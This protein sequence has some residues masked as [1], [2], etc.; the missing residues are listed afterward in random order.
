MADELFTTYLGDE[1][2]PSDFEVTAGNGYAICWNNDA[3]KAISRSVNAWFLGGTTTYEYSGQV[4]IT[5]T[6]N[7]TT[8]LNS[9]ADVAIPT[10]TGGWKMGGT[11]VWASSTPTATEIP[12][13]P[14]PGPTGFYLGGGA[15]LGEPEVVSTIPPSDVIVPEGGFA[16]CGSAET[17]NVATTFPASEVIVAAAGF[18]LGGEGVWGQV[19][20]A[21]ILSAVLVPTGGFILSGAGFPQTPGVTPTTTVIVPTG[22]WKFGG[23]QPDSLVVVY[24]GSAYDQ[25]IESEVAFEMGGEGIWGAQEDS[26]PSSTVIVSDGAIF[27]LAGGGLTGT[28]LSP[29]AVITGDALGGFVLGGGS[30]FPSLAEVYEA[31]CLSGQ[32]FEPSVFSGFNFNSFA[33]K[34]GQAY[35]ANEDGIYLLGADTDAGDPIQSGIRLGP[36]NAGFD[37]EKRLRSC[38]F[39]AG[40]NGTSVRVRTDD[41]REGVFKPE[42]DS[43]RVVVSRDL[44][45][46]EF[47]LDVM[48][49]EEISQF[50]M[51]F[52]RLARR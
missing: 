18:A 48:G 42:R 11:G 13:A 16:F 4:S 47:Q 12:A 14:E 33:V 26:L 45:G 39:G 43:N 8:E 52:L 7:A 9:G 6:P 31:W 38:Q 41:G 35:G 22:G 30:G 5:I 36:L 25:V 51:N 44:Q 17:G 20:P 46:R 2:D 10:S 50:E 19:A 15:E 32:S 21:D 3:G 24:P 1:Y 40:G 37:G 23:F 29:V 28:A 34:G 49:F 27:V